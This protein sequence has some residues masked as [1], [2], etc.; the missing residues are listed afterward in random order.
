[1]IR[2]L[3]PVTPTAELAGQLNAAGLTTGHGRPFDVKAVQ[4]IRHAYKIPAPAPYAASEISVAKAA[5]RLGCSA[6][7]IYY[8]IGAGQLAARRGP[9][10]RLCITWND[11][12]EAACRRRIAESGHLT[13]ATRPATPSPA[14]R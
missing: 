1:M 12:I 5:R 3:G 13:P 11:Q 10:N 4:W 14:A 6:G 9:G 2:R 8:W 7:V